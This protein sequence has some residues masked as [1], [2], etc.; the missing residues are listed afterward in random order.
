MRPCGTIP[1]KVAFLLI[2]SVIGSCL[3]AQTPI[4]N[5]SANKVAGCSPLIV[6]FQDA[7]AGATSWSWDFGNG[8]SSNIKNPSTTYL[9]PGTYTV[10]LTAT[11]ANG[12][13]TVT[14]TNYITVYEKP[15]VNF[16]ASD[17]FGCAPMGVQF[18]NLSNAGSGNTISSAI[19]DLGN[20]TTSAASNPSITYNTSGNFSVTLI[21]TNDKGCSNSLNKVKY[22]KVQP[23]VIADF[24]MSQPNVCRPPFGINFTNATTGSG[25]FTYQWNFGDG[26]SSAQSS[27]QHNYNTAGKYIVSLM[28]VSSTGCVD[29]IS[30]TLDI[31]SRVTSFNSVDT[32]C[33]NQQLNFT[34]NSVPNPSNSNWNFGDGT[35]SGSTSP[36]KIYANPGS[37]LVRLISTFSNCV[38]SAKKTI[39]VLPKATPDFTSPVKQVCK[40]PASIT[41][42]DQ[43]GPSAVSWFWKFGD[44]TTSSQQNPGHTYSTYGTYDVTLIVTNAN[45]CIDSIKKSAFINIQQPTIGFNPFT[46][47]GCLPFTLK[48]TVNISTFDNVTGYL[49]D[50]GDGTTSTQA[51]PTHT[52]TAQGKYT[53]SLTITTATGC[54]NSASLVDSVWAGNYPV[55][56]FNA[57]PIPVCA[58]T[59]VTFTNLTAPADQYQWVFGD[60]GKST[61]SN[62]IYEYN[63]PGTFDVAL[64]A[65]N[66]GCLDSL[67]KTQYITVFPPVARFRPNTD[68][69]NRL[70]YTFTD[71][72]IQPQ[73]WHWDFGD[74]T[75][76]TQQYPAHIFPA[77]GSYNVTL[78]VT[79]GTCQDTI[80]KTIKTIDENPDF[81]TAAPFACKNKNATFIATNIDKSLIR[82]YSWSFGDGT[83]LTAGLTDS[84]IK[85]TYNTEGTYSVKLITVDLNGCKDSVTKN[86]FFN[87]NG[88]KANFAAP[89]QSGCAGI[90][91]NFLDS[92][93]TDGRN[94]INTKTWIWGDKQSATINSSPYQHKYDSVGTFS[95]K[96]IVTDTSGCSDSLTRTNYITTTRPVIAFKA[97][98]STACPGSA[99]TFINSSSGSNLQYA[100]SFGDGGISSL[101]GPVYNYNATGNYDVKLKVIDQYNCTDSLTKVQY[102]NVTKPV[103]AFT[104]SDSVSL[105]PPFK[106]DFSNQS[107]TFSSVKWDFGDGSTTTLNNPSH[108]FT[109]VNSYT[110][111][112]IATHPKGC[113]DTSSQVVRILDS[114][115]IKISYSP[116][117]GCKPM[118][119]DFKATGAASGGFDYLWDFGNGVTDTSSGSSAHNIYNLYGN[120]VPRLIVQDHSGCVSAI[121]GVDTIKVRGAQSNFGADKNI[122]CVSG[123]VNFIDSTTSN[124]PIINYT[125]NF[126]DGQSSNQQQ[127]S[128]FYQNIGSYT[129]TLSTITQAGCKD[130]MTKAQ[131]ITLVDKPHINISGDSVICIHDTLRHIGNILVPDTAVIAWKWNFPNGNT[132]NVQ[133]PGVQKYDQA[134]NFT[135]TAIASRYPGC[136][137]TAYQKI[138]VN[139]LPTSSLPDELTKIAGYPVD[140]S[141]SY[142]NGVNKWSWDNSPDISCTNCA[143]PSFDPKMNKTF[144]VDFA[145]A[146]G[147]VNKDSVYIKILC[148]GSALFVPNTFSPNGDGSNDVFYPRGKGI[149]T[150]KLF[151]VFNRW[152]ELVF[153]KQNF[154]VNDVNAGWNGLYKG[155]KA[156]ADV[157]IFQCQA[158]CEN[159][160]LITLNGNVALI[161]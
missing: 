60:G 117:I 89:I 79:N 132:A 10:K 37:Y 8:S 19:W 148:P 93:T 113:T 65:W 156:P 49:W 27:P 69:N 131:L 84:V 4:A 115:N 7:S 107:S 50:F 31:P 80:T 68:C 86:S 82:S 127:P 77:F 13:N 159:N 39:I 158:Y 155:K 143:F 45:G 2:F 153:E 134:G 18:T 121:E 51:K 151:R 73:T 66:Y 43:S 28:A 150:V 6:S 42:Q 149:V 23:P 90:T 108:Y 154:Q 34:N 25:T 20:G 70:R 87:V 62:P 112:L 41:F 98:D 36:A 128:H 61:K 106:V 54:S 29:T 16:N 9:T 63:S 67:I 22:I 75:T 96:L 110:V 72:S 33:A 12:S 30:K 92:S 105:C 52:Y 95:V 35:V 161:Q 133:L 135:V 142:G 24:N 74:G 88:P 111:S 3:F 139:A 81:I 141:G 125:W 44:G 94:P 57:T 58:K 140:L 38:D 118:G 101:S 14:K 76:S 17:T 157:Y 136:T 126:G 104:M 56:D 114:T 109:Q 97:D 152:G 55:I 91:I 15:I 5:F 138:I 85:H 53:L 59:P 137:D 11:N 46:K 119:V 147:C 26:G 64:Y 124:D 32:I 145:D 130:T 129:V 40:V 47:R 123:T 102:I 122:F 78:I 144:T 146:N 100:W 83:P 103:S 120:F 160:E 99:V 1:A 21:I 71:Q 116:L 48:P